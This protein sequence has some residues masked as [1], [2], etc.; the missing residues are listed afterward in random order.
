MLSIIKTINEMDELEG[1]HRAALDSYGEV[2]RAAAEYPVEVQPSEAQIFR[3]HMLALRKMLENVM[4]AG[5]FQTIHASFRG[6]LRDYRDKANEWIAAM[7]AE[8]TAAAEAMQTLSVRVAENGDDHEARLQADLKKL[9]GLAECEDLGRIRATVQQVAGSISRSLGQLREA[10]N[11]MI[12]QL[13]DEIQSLHREMDNSR[14]SLFMDRGSGAWN[15]PKMEAQ[16]EELLERKEGFVAVVMWIS[17]LKRLEADCSQALIHGAMKA[18]VQRATAMVGAP[19]ANHAMIGRWAEDQF[20]MLLDIDA[21]AAV[22][23]AGDLG[24]KLC[25][26]YAVQEDGIS[27]QVTLHVS[28]AVVDQPLGGDRRKFRSRLDQ[29]SGVPPA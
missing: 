6:E 21:A 3:R 4:Q 11:L 8:L 27:H 18:M 22:A 2:L 16:I 13:R 1:V 19:S 10:N 24:P 26:R 17:N 28:M 9:T 23:I 20:L 25:S 5:D 14:R 7:R 15:R 12:A 29:M